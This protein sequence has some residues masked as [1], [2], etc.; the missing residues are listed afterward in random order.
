VHGLNKV[1][2]QVSNQIDSV[3]ILSDDILLYEYSQE[4]W[5]K[6]ELTAMKKQK[7]EEEKGSDVD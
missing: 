5:Q 3:T 6:M 7:E 4:N 1:R 2:S